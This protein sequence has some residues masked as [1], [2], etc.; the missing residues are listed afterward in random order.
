MKLLGS[1]SKGRLQ[2]N[3]KSLSSRVGSVGRQDKPWIDP[4][5]AQAAENA[6]GAGK[7]LSTQLKK[8]K[9]TGMKPTPR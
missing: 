2:R 4:E 8:N 7:M 6:G 9:S 3:K 5:R 1:G